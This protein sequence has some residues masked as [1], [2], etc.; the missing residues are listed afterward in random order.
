MSGGGMRILHISTNREWGGGENQILAL[1]RGLNEAGIDVRLAAMRGGALLREAAVLGEMVVPL[2]S[3]RIGPVKALMKRLQ[4]DLVH[5]HDSP[6][7]R[8]GGRAGRKLGVPVVLS[9]RVASPVRRNWFSQR[10]Y[11]APYFTAVLAVSETVGR[12]FVATSSYPAERVRVVP[13]GID[14]M[15]LDALEPDHRLREGL[16]G[17]PLVGG[18]GKLAP[19]KNWSFLLQTAAELKGRGVP[20]RWVVVGDGPE[21]SRLEG[22][23][24]EMGLA[25]TVQLMGFRREA[26]RILKS[27]DLLF[28]PSLMEGAGVIV[29]EAMVCRIPSVIVDTPGMMESLDGHGWVVP[30]GD[31]VRAAD[32]VAEALA[33]GERRRAVI[34]GA[35]ESALRRFSFE[36]TLARTLDAYRFIL[37]R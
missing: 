17:I 18:I 13:D 21:R 32:A 27:L 11:S 6:G 5:V 22:M 1:V 16:G 10:K 31:P 37:G 36:I 9:R 7:V 23:M 35:R 12:V 24:D 4:P 30:A 19:K 25:G 2:P 15:A 14:V 26:Q 20:L 8:A 28:A 29:R 3:T 33:D 34:E